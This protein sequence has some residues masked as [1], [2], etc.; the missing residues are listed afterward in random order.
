MRLDKQNG[1]KHY[2][3][4]IHEYCK[5][6]DRVIAALPEVKYKHASLPRMSDLEAAG[7][8]LKNK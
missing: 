5:V 7:R 1:I 2:A 3:G 8:W 4:I 6:D